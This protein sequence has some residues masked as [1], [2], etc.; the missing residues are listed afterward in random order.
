MPRATSPVCRVPLAAPKTASRPV[1][2]Q[3]TTICCPPSPLSRSVRL[4]CRPMGRR[5]STGPSFLA[6]QPF[7]NHPRRF[8][9][10]VKTAKRRYSNRDCPTDKACTCRN[11]SDRYATWDLFP[12]RP[13]CQA[14][15]CRIQVLRY[16]SGRPGR[17]HSKE[18]SLPV[19]DNVANAVRKSLPP[20]QMLVVSGSGSG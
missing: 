18:T 12:S 19:P 10:P 5:T 14:G 17:G 11:P 16:S 3:C 4:P 13:P 6:I 9:G 8:G 7:Q 15:P 20:K 1:G 2:A